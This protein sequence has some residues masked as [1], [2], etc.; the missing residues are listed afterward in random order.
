MSFLI[1]LLT[2]CMFGPAATA[3]AHDFHFSRTLV[4]YLADRQEVQVEMHI[5]IDDLELA[6]TEAGAPKLRLGSELEDPEAARYL[7]TYLDKHF[8]L[9]W[10]GEELPREMIGH[11]PSEDMQAI[12]IYFVATAEKAPQ[13]LGIRQSCL[14]E[15]YTDQRNL[16][17]VNLG[18]A[19]RANYLLYSGNTEEEQAF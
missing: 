4:R 18:E 8:K 3:P 12:W 2:A 17:Q 11:E 10:D 7:E 9:Y 16:V 15:I 6:L 5:F 19:G 13:K 1:T 14:T